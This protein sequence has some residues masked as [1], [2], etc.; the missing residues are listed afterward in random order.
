LALTYA[1][2]A[3]VLAFDLAVMCASVAAACC[4]LFNF[5]P[6]KIFYG[7]MQAQFHWDF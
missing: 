4:L 5:N 1:I 3:Y 6:A 2:A 7:G